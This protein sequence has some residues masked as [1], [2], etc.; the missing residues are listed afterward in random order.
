MGKLGNSE[1]NKHMRNIK[2]SR[3]G[4]GTSLGVFSD[5]LLAFIQKPRSL[6]DPS[7]I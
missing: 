3:E 6:G 2:R 1:N 4:A 7:G 5:N